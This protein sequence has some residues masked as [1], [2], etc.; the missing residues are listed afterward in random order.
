[1]VR[2]TVTV[3]NATGF[4]LGPTEHLN[5]T[6]VR[7]RSNISFEYGDTGTANAKSTLS[8]LGSG[9]KCGDEITVVCRGD[10][11]KEALEAIVAAIEDGL[12]E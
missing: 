11:E 9:V 1:M 10:D 8:V 5:K 2:Q 12:G 3:K 4:S 6:A 7:F